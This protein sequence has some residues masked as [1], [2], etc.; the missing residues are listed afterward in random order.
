MHETDNYKDKKQRY[1]LF[2]VYQ[3]DSIGICFTR[4]IKRAVF[5]IRWI[6][7]YFKQRV[8]L[9]SSRSTTSSK[10]ETDYVI[11]IITLQ[12]NAK[13]IHYIFQIYGWFLREQTLLA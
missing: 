7:S 9:R 6:E 10:Y 8:V 3:P 12:T 11:C 13:A 5:P 4:T 1:Y 2:L